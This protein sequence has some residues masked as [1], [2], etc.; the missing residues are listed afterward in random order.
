L[1]SHGK[2]MLVDGK[3]AVLGSISLAPGSLDSGRELAIA[4]DDPECCGQLSEFLDG[5]RP[6]RVF[7]KQGR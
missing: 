6:T 4:I 1:R 3:T 5:A 7:G 2:M